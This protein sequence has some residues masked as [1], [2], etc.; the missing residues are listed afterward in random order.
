[1]EM[2]RIQ[3]ISNGG[4]L[5]RFIAEFIK[6]STLK[7]FDAFDDYD[8]NIIDL[9]S[10][11]IWRNQKNSYNTINDIQN[12]KSL[13]M[14]ISL[15]KTS[16]IMIILPPDLDFLYYYS[17]V[18]GNYY[19]KVRLKDI[20]PTMLSIIGEIVFCNFNLIFSNTTS[21]INQESIKSSFV[22]N[23][24]SD[25]DIIVRS[26]KSG[27]PTAIQSFGIVFTTMHPENYSELISL[28]KATKL[29][30]EK[31]EEEP[32]WFKKIE[33]FDDIELN[34]IISEK[35]L[36]ILR[37]KETIAK[38]KE[39]L[40][41]NNRYKS[42]L[43]SQGQ[44]LVDV[45]FEMLQDML[46]IDLSNF[47]DKKIEDFR[48]DL[49]G[50]IY[51]GEIK[52]IT[53]NVNNSNITQLQLHVEH[54]LEDNENIIEDK[55]KGI[56][57]INHQRTKAPAERDPV[58]IRQINIASKKKYLIIETTTL[59]DLYEAFVRGELKTEDCISMLSN[60][61]LLKAS[62]VLSSR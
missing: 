62:D 60:N 26:E 34:N 31:G 50:I 52:G 11:M 7:E 36:D 3:I 54:F 45:V 38:S 21:K 32:E 48:F 56:L 28:L 2:N 44:E 12:F 20:I 39:K 58:D 22:F 18:S 9:S 15:A 1:M 10:E 41:Q 43:Y 53:K 59:L 24:I 37:M 46:G 42:I 16:K 6:Q 51:L 5:H 57:I 29:I 47:E 4:R 35:E 61:G 40:K 27:Q 13:K 55:V 49:G 14:S 25:T 30:K 17:S 19:D 33:K 23:D 8:I